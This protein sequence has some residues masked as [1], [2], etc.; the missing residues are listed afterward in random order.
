MRGAEHDTG[1]PVR[2]KARAGAGR[3][4]QRS[5]RAVSAKAL[6]TRNDRQPKRPRDQMGSVSAAP[7]RAWRR[8]PCQ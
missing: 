8:G 4:G 3:T 5:E 2:T 1:S 6:L 7:L